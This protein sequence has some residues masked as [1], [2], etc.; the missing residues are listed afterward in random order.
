[1]SFFVL[2]IAINF[3]T[4]H[5]IGDEWIEE[6]FIDKASLFLRVLD[7][8]WKIAEREA[9]SIANLL[10]RIGVGKNSS[11]LDLGCGNGRISVNL[12]K[13]GYRVVGVDISPLFISDAEKKALEHGVSG[14]V[15]FLVGDA[16]KLDKVLGDRLFDAVIMYWTTLIGYYRER[17]TDT[18]ILENV[19]RVTRPNGYLL[20][21]GHL[22]LETLS[23]RQSI[24][25]QPHY[26]S[27][28][29]EEFVVVEKPRYDPSTAILYNTWV[30][31]K[32]ND[33]NLIYI[34]EINFNLRIYAFHELVE[35][36]REAGWSLHSAY[37]DITTLRPYR[38][39]VGT[40][41][42]VFVK[43]NRK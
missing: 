17:K 11:I 43:Q 7:S 38:P 35:L 12:A 25:G 8:K 5:I 13:L 19:W 16:R 34:D 20:I 3:N 21:L 15:E 28:L 6:I 39:G 2:V 32:K 36:A 4:E 14:K 22:C 42:V 24:C 27:D 37:S 1:M 33:K 9:K 18:L 26:I 41:N 40:I 29:D 30:F 10:E 31:Y 23:V